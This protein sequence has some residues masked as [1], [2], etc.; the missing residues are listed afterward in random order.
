MDVVVLLGRLLFGALFVVS[1]VMGHLMQTTAMTGYAQ[2]KGIPAPR[3]AVVGSGVLITVAGLMVIFGIWGD[4]GALLLFV[5]LVPTA[6]VMHAFWQEPDPPTRVNEMNHF[7]KDI[8]SA[9]AALVL[10]GVYSSEAIGL[11]ITGP[12]L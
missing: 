9:G 3:A 10:L 4:L 8:A 12:L 11:T 5:F 7:F 6:V 1:G 2:S